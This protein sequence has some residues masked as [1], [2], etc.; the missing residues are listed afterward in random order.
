[1]TTFLIDDEV[2]CTDVLKVLLE[3]YCLNDIQ[4]AGIFNDAEQ[5]AEAITQSPPQLLF[6][7]VEMPRLN[8]FDLLKRCEPLNSKVIFTTAYDQYAIKAFKFNA[9]D[10]LLKPIDKNELQAAVKKA[11]Q[12][13][14][15]GLQQ[16]N[17]A[18]YLRSNPSPERLALPIGQELLLVDVADILFF[19]SDGSYVSVFIKNQNKPLVLAKSLR[20]FEE[21]LNNPD[22]FRAHN[23]YLI[24]LKYIKKIVRTDGGEIVMANGRSLPIARTKKADLM[25][26]ISKI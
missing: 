11:A 24:H 3:K 25:A 16:L 20:E 26:L 18:Q 9:L 6:L 4:I 8:G 21:F 1:M 22:F 23:S 17:A 7:D 14:S 15:P 5:A 13:L 10:Y 19:E 2:H 12:S